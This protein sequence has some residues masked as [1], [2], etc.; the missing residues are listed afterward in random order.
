M[1]AA[2]LTIGQRETF[3]ELANRDISLDRIRTLIEMRAYD[4]WN[5][6]ET[7]IIWVTT[8]EANTLLSVWDT[9]TPR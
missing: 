7:E 4:Q 5:S 6:S 2:C 8:E 3:N 9:I 1:F